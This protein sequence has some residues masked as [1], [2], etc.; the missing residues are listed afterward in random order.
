MIQSHQVC[1]EVKGS[2]KSTLFKG[3]KSKRKCHQMQL[4]CT[5]VVWNIIK[6]LSPELGT[7]TLLTSI[8]DGCYEVKKH[9]TF[10]CYS[11]TNPWRKS[12]Y[13]LSITV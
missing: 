2:V 13:L 9:F 12:F 4:I 10:R 7:H 1:C 5:G 11:V 6:C 8:V 3:L